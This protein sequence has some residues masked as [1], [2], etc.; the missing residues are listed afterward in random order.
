MLMMYSTVWL[1]RYNRWGSRPKK[2][3]ARRPCWHI[4]RASGGHFRPLT[5]HRITLVGGQETKGGREWYG[6]IEI[7]LGLSVRERGR[8]PKRQRTNK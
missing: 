6:F 1:L 5:P 2:K 3:Q 7:F 8:C 4:R